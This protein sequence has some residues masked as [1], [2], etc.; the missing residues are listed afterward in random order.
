MPK[1]IPTNPCPRCSCKKVS[2][3]RDIKS[4]PPMK[5]MEYYAKRGVYLIP[6]SSPEL[7]EYNRVCVQCRY[8]W[9]EEE[10][11]L[12]LEKEKYQEYLKERG[13]EDIYYHPPGI[14]S[15]VKDIVNRLF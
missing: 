7:P 11:E 10:Q 5:A 13:L 6:W 8:P 3:I 2:I 14:F 9:K 12:F 1:I 4:K 15:R